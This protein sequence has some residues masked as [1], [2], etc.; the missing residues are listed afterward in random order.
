[1]DRARHWAA[2]GVAGGQPVCAGLRSF[3]RGLGHGADWWGGRG[4]AVATLHC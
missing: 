1:M 4:L 2:S 3:W